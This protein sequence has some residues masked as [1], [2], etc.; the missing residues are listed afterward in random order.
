M[1]LG[2]RAFCC[3]DQERALSFGRQL[4]VVPQS[5]HWIREDPLRLGLLNAENYVKISS[6]PAGRKRGAGA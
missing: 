5:W 3:G 6:G 1:V 4:E 2:K